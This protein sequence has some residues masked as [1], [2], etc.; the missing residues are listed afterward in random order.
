[1]IPVYCTAAKKGVGI[2]ELLETLTANAIS[3]VQGKERVAAKK[4]GEEVVV[5]P[6]PAGEVVG[7][8]FTRPS[9]TSSSAT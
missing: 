4:G 5:K 9:P 1:M 6:D 8:V 2:P 3:P 7:Q